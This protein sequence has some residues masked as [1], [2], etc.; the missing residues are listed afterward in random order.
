MKLQEVSCQ[1]S[2]EQFWQEFFL[3]GTPVIFRDAQRIQGQISALVEHVK[4]LLAKNEARGVGVSVWLPSE[5]LEDFAPLPPWASHCFKDKNTHLLYKDARLFSCPGGH[6]TSW[7]YDANLL[8]NFNLQLAGKK[9]WTLLSPDFPRPCYG[10][11]QY[12]LIGEN[13]A[14]PENSF[15]FVLNAGDILYIPPL[16]MHEVT[17]LE[18]DSL[19][20]SW[21]GVN[22]KAIMPSKTLQRETE[23]LKLAYI[24]RKINLDHHLVKLMQVRPRHFTLF[25]GQG[26]D[27]IK[28][29]TADV[30]ISR[31]LIRVLKELYHKPHYFLHRK[32]IRTALK[33]PKMIF[34]ENEDRGNLFKY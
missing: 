26:W 3:T 22:D 32:K 30:S 11:S 9:K 21:I 12:G 28:Q 18:E 29:L 31:V 24:L 10:F 19:S 16:W 2:I 17:A 20:V 6:H 34:F 7:H 1:I 23:M 25:G 4:N 8:F 33:K 14:A 27:Y 15:T 5:K 13:T